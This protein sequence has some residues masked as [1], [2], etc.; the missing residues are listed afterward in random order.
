MFEVILFSVVQAIIF[1][2][3][4]RR[5]VEAAKT[6]E[7]T[8][9]YLYAHSDHD[10]GLNSRTSAL[11]AIATNFQTASVL[12]V[13]I[14][15]GYTYGITILWTAATFA[16]GIVLLR[17]YI[18]KLS[19]T[20]KSSVLEHTELPYDRLFGTASSKKSNL[21]ISLIYISILFSAVLEIWFGS[22]LVSGIATPIIDQSGLSNTP[23][24]L[25]LGVTAITLASLLFVYVFLGGYRAVALTDE[26]QYKLIW[27]MLVMLLLG[28]IIQIS[29]AES[30][31]FSKLF[32]GSG[33]IEADPFSYV[34]LLIGV[35][36]LNFF[37]QFVDPQQWQ[38]ARASDDST[39]Y[40]RS[41]TQAAL[42]TFF[43]WAVP[44]IAGATLAGA[45]VDESLAATASTPFVAI[46]T[47][48]GESALGGA[49]AASIVAVA[50][51]GIIAAAVS[52]ADTAV[53]AALAKLASIQNLDKDLDE[54][55]K[56]G[57][58]IT[59]MACIVAAIIYNLEPKVEN[60]IFAVYSAVVMF[61]GPFMYFVR[62]GGKAVVKNNNSANSMAI[63]FVIFLVS[64]FIINFV[65][66]F[67]DNVPYASF[68]LPAVSVF[69]GIV[70]AKSSWLVVKG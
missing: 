67:G 51:A 65:P 55:R 13:G 23:E 41:L 15:F 29:T 48:I 39:T 26:I 3:L 69:Y 57:V 66:W 8:E 70:M 19:Q 43:T 21:L 49:I 68:L 34:A 9:Q 37:W 52:S 63:S 31:Q 27:T 54:T 14:Y 22:S 32:L 53:M 18:Q 24:G 10:G 33:A 56:K 16:G 7:N 47:F 30:F 17:L 36:F 12:F 50:A 4:I 45:S 42:W 20:D 28:V 6:I 62:T 38:R 1:F 59:M 44:I 35:F 64:A 5:S 11:T 40:S 60:A 46:Y 58:L 2:F 25:A 61:A